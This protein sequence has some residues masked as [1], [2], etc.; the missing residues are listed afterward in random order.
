METREWWVPLVTLFQWL[1]FIRST[2]SRVLVW[3][4]PNSKVGFIAP[5]PLCG[6]LLRYSLELFWFCTCEIFHLTRS[7]SEGVFLSGQTKVWNSSFHSACSL[8]NANSVW[9][10]PRRLSLVISTNTVYIFY[11]LF[12][13]IGGTFF[14]SIESPGSKVCTEW[15][16]GKKEKNL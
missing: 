2:L 15:L 11:C 9:I 8:Y 16:R 14:V 12:L 4:K 10:N 6:N 1:V 13:R 5:L 7:R 3:K